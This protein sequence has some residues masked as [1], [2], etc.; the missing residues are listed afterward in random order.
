MRH[1]IVRLVVVAFLLATGLLAA[2][3]QSQSTQ[4]L[5]DTTRAS[6]PETG[7]L[8]P[9]LSAPAVIT[10]PTVGT[11]S[12]TEQSIIA[13]ARADARRRHSGLAWGFGGG[14][15]GAGAMGASGGMVLSFTGS[16]GGYLVGGAV[17]A[18]PVPLLA[19]LMKVSVP[20]SPQLEDA[21]P[22]QRVIYRQVFI[23]ESR[24]LRRTSV[25]NAELVIAGGF[26]LL[27]L[28]L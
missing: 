27:I 21:T 9:A 28:A 1:I 18:L 14:L 2:P 3:P 7:G 15:M 8:I 24:K 6:D 16:F 23:P 4:Q 10:P 11:T 26:L 5:P 25:I 20:E 17:G 19:S 22:G 12:L 13:L